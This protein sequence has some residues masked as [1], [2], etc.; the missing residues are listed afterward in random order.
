MTITLTLILALAA[1]FAAVSIDSLLRPM[2]ALL[3][4]QPLASR[5]GLNASPVSKQ[6]TRYVF[7]LLWPARYSRFS[8][9]PLSQLIS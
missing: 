3:A 9:K 8:L 1:T 2:S 5:T 4:D 6:R 7:L